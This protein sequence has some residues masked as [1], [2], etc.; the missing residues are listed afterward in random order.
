[1]VLCLF[2]IWTLRPFG[3]GTMAWR[4]TMACGGTLLTMACGGTIAC[5]GTMA[6]RAYQTWLW[7]FV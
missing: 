4:G 3:H 2:D 5:A 1:M 6:C 7:A